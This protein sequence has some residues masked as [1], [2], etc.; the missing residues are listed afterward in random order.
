MNILL[1]YSTYFF[2]AATKRESGTYPAH[3]EIRK[4]PRKSALLGGLST[5]FD[6]RGRNNTTYYNTTQHHTP[7]QLSVMNSSS[8]CGLL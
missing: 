8:K 3:Y 4:K 2:V 6:I 5:Q 7:S 1:T